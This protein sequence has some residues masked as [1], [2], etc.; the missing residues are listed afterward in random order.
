[1]SGPLSLFSAADM[2]ALQAPLEAVQDSFSKTIRVYKSPERAAIVSDSNFNFMFGS[3][4]PSVE[5]TFEPNYQDFQ[6]VVQWG[7]T[8]PTHDQEN[9]RETIPAGVC[10]IKC[11]VDLINFLQGVEYIEIDSR[12]CTIEGTPRPHGLFDTTTYTIWA[13]EN[14]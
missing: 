2:A 6:A 11:R 4:Q 14:K 10:R 7:T 8:T 1:M 12:P 13:R 3:D 9:I 5:E